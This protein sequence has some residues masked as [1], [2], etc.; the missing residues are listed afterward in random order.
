M[1]N[2]KEKLIKE[3][4][5]NAVTYA[6]L[7]ILG[8]IA[9]VIV[10]KSTALYGP[11]ISSD[12]LYYISTAK[13][14]VEGKG[15]YGFDEEPY[16]HWPPLFP[17]LL[18]MLGLAGIEPLNGARFVN[19]VSFALIVFCS[20]IVFS[21]RIKSL[22][23]V[24]LGAS[25][26]LVSATMLRISVFAWTEPLFALLVIFFMLT[27]V[28][29]LKTSQF[30]SLVFAGVLAA[31]ACLQ[32][33]VGIAIVMAGVAMIFLL[34]HKTKWR[35]KL[36]AA[37]IFGAVSCTPLGLWFLRNRL[38]ASTVADYR[39]WLDTTLFKEVTK[40]LDSLT[41]W[42][43]TDKITLV[44]RLVIISVFG[45]LLC[46]AVV[47]RNRKCGKEQHG[48]TML[49]KAAFA[50]IVVYG[51]FTTTAAV[52]V[53]ADADYRIYSSVYVFLILLILIGL[54][55]AGKLLSLILKKDQAGYLVVT[56]LCS[57]W[58]IFYPLPKVKEQ[59]A[60]YQKYGVPG[61]NSSFWRQSPLVN[62]LKK[63]PLDG[64]LFSN[65]PFPLALWSGLSIKITPNRLSGLENFR[66]QILSSRKSYLLWHYRHWRTHLYNL[67]E[68]NAQFK[69]K[70]IAK[71][72][73]GVVFEIQ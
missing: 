10:L 49:V 52:Y 7:S 26:V 32:R 34:T 38:I 11:G 63:Y 48:D 44:A 30:K 22:L 67:E 8:V 54:E 50:L 9:A 4:H 12:A 46:V 17:T 20:G 42:F 71:L 2:N 3:R 61:Y 70:P 62:W 29:F 35:D 66:R 72:P 15:Y 51:I 53:N 64:Q 37:A 23:L 45:C 16:T 6:A 5:I 43:V 19:A 56:L 39:L 31:L 60:Y 1:S 57:L 13:G 33:Y 21:R 36:K 25:S 41:T 69:L 27:M 59:F 65:E 18:A 14:L 73:D 68:L 58:L 24:I 55:A 28:Q 40:T 47:L